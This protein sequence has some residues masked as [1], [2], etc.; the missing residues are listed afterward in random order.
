MVQISQASK[1][2]RG[3]Y[4]GGQ[5]GD[6]T[7]QEL[8][9]RSLW[10]N[11]W[12]SLIVW[13]DAG[14]GRE[15]GQQALNAANNPMIGYDQSERNTILTA[16]RAVDFDLSRVSTPC[17]TDCSALGGTCGIAAGAPESIIYEGGNLCYTGNIA[18]RFER[19]GLVK[20]YRGLSYN[21]IL[22]RATAG[23]ILTSSGHTVIVT[24]GAD[25]VTSPSAPTTI[26][27]IYVDGQWGCATTRLT[28]VTLGTIADG[29]VSGQDRDDMIAVNRGGL[30][31]S[32]WKIGSGGSD[33][34]AALQSLVGAKKDRY[35]GKESC[36]ALQAF[37]GTTQDGYISPA[38]E[39]VKAHQRWLNE[40]AA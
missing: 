40:Q 8:N 30:E 9:T 10:D 35:F 12:L 24:D 2:E 39:C 5:A 4:S 7:G 34:V 28:Q 22:T 23:S 36:L 25:L 15:C 32:S 38:S 14:R 3:K 37:H 13:I 18:E 33:M 29:I 27:G 19:T 11:A 31:S 26:S 16:A 17:E 1:D 21:E 20:V 6:Q